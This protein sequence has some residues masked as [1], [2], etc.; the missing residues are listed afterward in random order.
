MVLINLYNGFTAMYMGVLENQKNSYEGLFC[1]GGNT[2]LVSH[3]FAS[4]KQNL[5]IPKIE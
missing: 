4:I 5:E 2:Y 3:L 1:F